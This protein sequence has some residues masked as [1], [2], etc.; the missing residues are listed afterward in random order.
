MTRRAASRM[1]VVGSMLLATAWL[2]AGFAVRGA[3]PTRA[4][5]AAFRAAVARV[6]GA[7]VRIEPPAGA[8]AAIDSGPSTG[9]VIDPQGLILA[10]EFAV[11]DR[12]AEVVVSTAAAGRR[13]AR[14]RGRDRGRGLV[15]LETEAVPDAPALEPAPREQLRPGQWAIAVGRGWPAAEPGVSVGVVSAI[16]RCWGLAVQTDAAVSPMNY[17]G[18]LVDVSGRV[19]GLLVPLPA[20]TAGMQRGSDLY[21]S[22][23]GFAIPLAEVLPLVP[24][25]RAGERLEPG[26]LGL[27]WESR[28][29]INGEPVIGGVP[30]GSPAAA[31]G[32]ASGDRVIG[33]A[34][35]TVNRVA[36]V[37]HAL[38]PLHAGDDVV[39][40]V[41]RIAGHARPQRLSLTATLAD[42][43]PPTRR[44]L[45]GIVAA[46]ADGATRIAWLLPAGPAAHGGAVVG[47]VVASIAALP[48]G[49]VA[50]LESPPPRAV[51]QFLATLPP[52]RMVRLEVDRG[53]SRLPL[54][55]E[56]AA[57]PNDVPAEGPPAHRAA[58][59]LEGVVEPVKVV[60]LAAA[61]TSA[62]PV[63]VMP[64]AGTDPL[65]V[66]VHFGPPRGAVADDEAAPWRAAVATTGV[67]VILP[68]SSDERRWSRDDIPGVLRAIQS[69]AGRRRIDPDR[70][71]VS[72]SGAG[73]AFAWLVAERLGSACRGVAVVDA[74]LPAVT[75][76]TAAPGEAR[77]ILLGGGEP[78]SRVLAE[79]RRLEDAGHVVG[80][81]GVTAESSP[82]TLCRWVSL[83]GL[84]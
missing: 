46:D 82:A 35:R 84:L 29:S 18:P 16:D 25:L 26:V 23:I 30:A 59:P 10:S 71:A 2:P 52:G 54:E 47:D 40:D 5:E 65:G 61:E 69:L 1:I 67:A 49:D 70:I 31:A 41:E 39:I 58:G 48:P 38:A 55:I 79:R 27:A 42:R 77:W 72:G 22:G 83:L 11:P 13:L 20:D 64:R 56:L 68:G 63:A 43:L 78:A 66:L 15:L 21:D 14:V 8:G 57:P 33:V 4:E 50:P 24:R 37:R 73:G 28:D 3:E 32:L 12:V 51:A 45:L 76:V 44:G 34:G 53:G 9:L 81:L 62:R 36:D 7:V 60:R 75:P 74:S 19:I 80:D 17:G 6:A